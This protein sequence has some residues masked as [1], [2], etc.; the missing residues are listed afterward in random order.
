MIGETVRV[1]LEGYDVDGLIKIKD[2]YWA[3]E[4]TPVIDGVW[5]LRVEND[6]AVDRLS[7]LQKRVR[8]LYKYTLIADHFICCV[9]CM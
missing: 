9:L 4:G 2:I 6:L 7:H 1:N 5:W 3:H 8:A